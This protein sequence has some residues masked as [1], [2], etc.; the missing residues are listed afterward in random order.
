[1]NQSH[2]KSVLTKRLNHIYVSFILIINLKTI[3]KFSRRLFVDQIEKKIN[4]SQFKKYFHYTY[5]CYI[6]L[7]CMCTRYFLKKLC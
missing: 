3:L 4:S 7:K 1:M 6:Y 2:H 5:V